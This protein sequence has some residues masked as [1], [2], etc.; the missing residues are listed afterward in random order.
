MTQDEWYRLRGIVHA[1]LRA[2]NPLWRYYPEPSRH[3]HHDA[4]ALF[5]TGGGAGPDYNYAF[6]LDRIAPRRLFALADAFFR[7]GDDWSVAVAAGVAPEV[8]AALAERG[9]ALD[10]EEPALVLADI[11]P[12]PAPPGDLAIR[13]VRDERGLRDFRALSPNSQV[14][15][16]S[17]AA[18]TD[19]AVGLLVGYRDDRPV[20]ASRLACLGE[21]AEITGVR[22]RP[23]ERRRGF[24]T[25]M[26][27]AAVGE[28]AA[29]GCPTIMLNAS[30]LGFPIYR[31]M[32][33]V[34]VCS[35][36]T[37]LP[38]GADAG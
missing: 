28:A 2:P 8:E 34:P 15:V 21:T 36:R 27:W 35:Y 31:R 17:L 1:A 38:P 18:A 9:W 5:A 23:E 12:I 33:F 20:A 10:E 16:P 7:P 25:A 26:T 13:P 22:T 37:Y 30:P 3:E 6:V 29:R 11:P 24:G 14:F 19:P 4:V 32:G